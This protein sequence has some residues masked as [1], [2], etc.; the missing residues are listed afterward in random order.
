MLLIAPDSFKGSANSKVVAEALAEG[1]RQ[2]LPDEPLVC[3]PLADGGEGTTTVIQHAV[4]G[5]VIPVETVDAWGRPIRA[6]Y[7][8]CGQS[9]LGL[10][11]PVSI[12]EWACAAGFVDR[13]SPGEACRADSSGVG[14][15]IRAAVREGCRSLLLGLGGSATSDGGAG[16]L[17]ELGAELLD[18]TGRQLPL[19]GAALQHLAEVRNAGLLQL[20]TILLADVHI[21]LHGATGTVALFAAQKG[22]DRDARGELDRGLRRWSAITD[23]DFR[24]VNDDGAGAAGGAGFGLAAMLDARILPGAATVADICGLDARLAHADAVWTGEGRLDATTIQGK[25][26]ATVLDRVRVCGRRIPVTLVGGDLGAGADVVDVP[27]VTRIATLVE[28]PSF[29]PPPSWRSTGNLLGRDQA[30]TH[31]ATELSRAARAIARARARE[32]RAGVL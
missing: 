8:R 17:R 5:D 28:P 19:G 18:S 27:P 31:P 32:R 9:L 11:A 29:A 20:P 4:G 3:L 14:R 12:V 25:V 6:E 10:P 22:A 30:M 24:H 7:V 15:V 16:L 13:R 26:V 23:P 2:V 21:P 1:V